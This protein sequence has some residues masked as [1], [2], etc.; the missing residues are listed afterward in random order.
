MVSHIGVTY[1]QQA[2]LVAN[3]SRY[4]EEASADSLLDIGAGSP[5]TALPLSKRVHRYRAIERDP[6][7]AAR[8]E[9]AGLS[10]TAGTFPLPMDGT[11][12]LVLS[13]HSVPENSLEAYAPF[14]SSAWELTSPEGMLLIV[15]FKG[16]KGDLAE[17]AHDLLGLA[18]RKS[19]G[20]EHIIRSYEEFGGHIGIERVNS[21]VEGLAAEDIAFFL[22]PW[23]SGDGRERE[24][25]HSDFVRIIETRYKVRRNLFVFPTEHL[26][27][28]C[29]KQKWARK[30]L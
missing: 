4:I 10:V 18:P 13:S 17:I 12:D 27:L 26:F 1:H 28:V 24:S 23:L 19:E 25:I 9:N 14:L 6:D 30:S 22:E 3:I 5:E 15:T 7:A 29:R 16:S 8:L 2:T 11:Y 21:Y 20:L